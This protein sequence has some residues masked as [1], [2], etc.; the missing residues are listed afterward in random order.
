MNVEARMNKS[1]HHSIFLKK[2]IKKYYHDRFVYEWEG[3]HLWKSFIPTNKHIM[4]CNNDYL[5]LRQD[6]DL[7]FRN[8]NGIDKNILMSSIFQDAS[9]LQAKLEEE[10]AIFF[11]SEQSIISQSGWMANVGLV[12]SIADEAIPVYIDSSAHMSFYDGIRLANAKSHVFLHNNPD[13]AR[14]KIH[15]YGPG[16]IIIDSV[17]SSNGS[18]C[19]LYDFVNLA[20]ETGSIIVVDESHSAGTHGEE[21]RGLVNALGLA[22]HVDFIT[23]SLAKAFA[24]RAG[25]I[26]CNSDFKDYFMTVSHP[27]I[28]SSAVM[29]SD[30]QWFLDAIPFI[31]NCEERRQNLHKNAKFLRSELQDIGYDVSGGTEQIIAVEAGLEKDLKNLHQRLYDKGIIGSPFCY[32]AT[33]KKR[34]LLRLTVNSGLSETDLFKI[35]K[36]FKE[37]AVNR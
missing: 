25:L 31:R 1:K 14:K 19:P 29:N 10:F 17:Y 15:H 11:N 9:G 8:K 32:P 36:I 16:V 22:H 33:R 5:C 20:R 23:V 12:Q 21:G 35:I 37:I 13:I 7:F 6:S 26:T 18:L 3:T 4:L 2:R 24:G 27:A 28:F 34:A 30:L